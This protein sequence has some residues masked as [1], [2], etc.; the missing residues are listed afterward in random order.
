MLPRYSLPPMCHLESKMELGREQ[1]EKR[2]VPF[3][4]SYWVVP[5]KLMAG[6]LPGST[7][8]EEAL[9]KLKGMLECGIRVVVNLMESHERDHGGNVF[10]AY[11]EQLRS[12]ARDS[13]AEIT[14]VSFP[15]KDQWI[16]S[17]VQMCR[18]LDCIDAFIE[19]GHP[20]YVHCWG[21]I[22]RTGTVVGCYLARHGHASDHQVLEMIRQLRRNV[23]DA[24]KTSP[25][26]NSQMDLVLSWVE[27]E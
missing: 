2:N 24:H 10:I 11:D 13:G 27:G 6:C 1:M 3:N 17:R 16:P 23:E 18:I 20:V 26:T 19:K 8:P 15:I 7:D 12:L 9:Q 22:G 5:G 21:G 25:E 14:L 4:R